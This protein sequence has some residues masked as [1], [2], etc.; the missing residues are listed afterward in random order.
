MYVN[1]INRKTVLVISDIRPQCILISVKIK[2]P[3]VFL[4][5]KNV[6]CFLPLTSIYTLIKSSIYMI[7]S[8]SI[9]GIH[10][11]GL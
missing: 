1:D 4:D 8:D 3:R 2:K 6:H 11:A 7:M 9:Y 5:K 10:Y